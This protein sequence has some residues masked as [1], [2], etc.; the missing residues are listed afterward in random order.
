MSVKTWSG[1]PD[2]LVFYI[3]VYKLLNYNR[4][5][6]DILT[7]SKC[8]TFSLR[9]IVTHNELFSI[10]L[11]DTPSQVDWLRQVSFFYVVEIV[12]RARLVIHCI[13]WPIGKDYCSVTNTKMFRKSDS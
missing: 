4:G 10:G 9:S 6:G 2:V 5:E 11:P 3:L 1:Y 12:Q 7:R 13:W 8:V